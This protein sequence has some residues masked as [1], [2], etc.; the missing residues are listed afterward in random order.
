MNL[1]ACDALIENYTLGF[2][3]ANHGTRMMLNMCLS[4]QFTLLLTHRLCLLNS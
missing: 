4:T 1:E 3:T 2:L